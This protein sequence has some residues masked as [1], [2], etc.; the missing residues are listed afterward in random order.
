[1]ITVDWETYVQLL[2][3]VQNSIIAAAVLGILGGLIG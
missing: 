1:M 2:A 3:L